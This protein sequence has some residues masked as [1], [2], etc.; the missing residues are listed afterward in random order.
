LVEHITGPWSVQ[1]WLALAGFREG[2]VARPIH[3]VW[4]PKEET[5]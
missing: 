1:A 4:E 3:D 5:A 2:V